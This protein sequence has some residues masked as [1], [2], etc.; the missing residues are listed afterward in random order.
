M[1]KPAEF[2]ALSRFVL[3]LSLILPAHLGAQVDSSSVSFFPSTVGNAWRYQYSQSS[4]YTTA[5]TRDSVS[6]GLRYLFMD[7]TDVPEY[8]LDSSL[9]VIEYPTTAYRRLQYK[10]M[11]QKGETWVVYPLGPT[12]RVVARV[13]D[14][15]WTYVLGTATQVKRIGYYYQPMSDTLN[16]SSW[17]L[18]QYLAAGFGFY[19]EITDA[20]Q[21]ASKELYGCVIDGRTYGTMVGVEKYLAHQPPREFQLLPAFPNPFNPSTNL[22]FELSKRNYVILE[23]YDLLGRKT[24]TLIQKELASGSHRISFTPSASS[25]GIYFVR[26]TVGNHSQSSKIIYSK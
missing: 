9:E 14:V 23:V 4:G 24:A 19:L 1:S 5:I 25:S 21:T 2:R 18:D 20:M 3:A 13:D 11:A 8:E 15:F 12:T 7:S 16:F 6:S 17:Q 10:L 26:M 22:T